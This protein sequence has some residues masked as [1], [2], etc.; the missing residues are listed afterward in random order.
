MIKYEN[1]FTEQEV[2]EEH[3]FHISKADLVRMEVEEH[4]EAYTDKEGQ[5][6]TGM[7][8]KLQRIVDAEDGKAIM[9]EFEDIIR[10]SYG[11]RDGD[12][13]LRSPEI[14]ADFHGSGAYDQLMFE[15]CTDAEA[16]ATFVN[17]LVPNNLE[18]IAAEIKQEGA[19]QIA[20]KKPAA[21]K[22][23]AKKA[24]E[25]TVPFESAERSTQIA[26]ATTE[27]PIELTHDELVNMEADP[28][29]SGLASGKF[30]L[31]GAL[32]V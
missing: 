20:A 29:K 12:R 32:A 3:W 23:S 9:R 4:Q 27:N 5:E 19:E 8:A 26:E 24:A 31:P 13:F 17:G 6:L 7:Q 2:I 25:S 22:R 10:R 18:K 1:P 21:K 28:L 15:I 14:W 11:R 16:A 30:K